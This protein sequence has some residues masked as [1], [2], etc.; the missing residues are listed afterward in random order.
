MK[1]LSLFSSIFIV[2][3]IYICYYFAMLNKVKRFFHSPKNEMYSLQTDVH[4]H[5]LPGIDDGSKSLD[6]SIALI[7]ALN[8]LGYT[9]FITTPHTMMHR[10]PN[11]SESI[12]RALDTLQNGLENAQVPVTIEAASE[13]YLD[14]HFV[15]L[16]NNKDLLTFGNNLVLFEMSYVM[17]PV[18]LDRILSSLQDSGYTPVLAHPER[19]LYFHTN[20]DSYAL[21]KQKGVMFQVNINSLG[22]YY[23]K[24]VQSAA[25]TL[26]K[27]GWIDYL[28]SDVHHQKH[29]DALAATLKSGVL[30][31]V[32]KNNTILNHQL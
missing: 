19:Y 16:I 23:S 18:E 8:H 28:G 15:D 1:K 21:L 32:M 29:I 5:L 7:S 31:D 11:S 10:Y 2:V 3:L 24:S 13:Y 22:G 6:E 26:M 4:S 9:R 12:L 14:E 17:A 25:R 30:K 27:N 20:N